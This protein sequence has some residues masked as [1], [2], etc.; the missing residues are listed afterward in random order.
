MDQLLS[1]TKEMTTTNGTTFETPYSDEEAASK[2]LGSREESESFF[3]ELAE[4]YQESGSL[5]EAQRPYLHKGALQADG[6]WDDGSP[7]SVDGFE[8][9]V[10][11][12]EE[13][14]ASGLSYP[15]IKIVEEA[16]EPGLRMYRA[17]SRSSRP[18]SVAVTDAEGEA[19]WGRI[20]KNGTFHPRE[21]V[22]EW[23]VEVLEEFA[24]D[25]ALIARK[26]GQVTGKCCFCG[27]EL[28]EE[29]SISVGYGPIC[30]ENFGLSHPQN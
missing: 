27:L 6:S 5:S 9:I 1:A 20:R 23:A 4:E 8:A 16:P 3:V 19:F 24:S 10:G 29:G 11:H 17:S 25:P 18:G 7:D 2:V 26:E 14:H 22:P 21:S 15:S 28:T 13:A 30:A 12:F